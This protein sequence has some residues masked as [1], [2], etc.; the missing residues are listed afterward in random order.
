MCFRAIYLGI[1]VIL[2][3]I[4]IASYTDSGIG[5]FAD[6]NSPEKLSQ[7][8]VI[9]R[10]DFSPQAAGREPDVVLQTAAPSSML[11][12]NSDVRKKIAR[13]KQSTITSTLSKNRT[14]TQFWNGHR[15]DNLVCVSVLH[16]FAHDPSAFTQGVT[17]YKRIWF[18]STGLD[19]QS[20]L[21]KVNVLTGKP[22]R[23]IRLPKDV[24]AE[25]VE[26]MHNRVYQLTYRN[27]MVFLYDATTFQSIGTLPYPL[28]AFQE[29]WGITSDRDKRLFVSDGSSTIFV[30]NQKFELQRRLTVTDAQGEVSML[31]ELEY[32]DGEIW[33]NVFMTD[34]IIR[35]SPDDGHAI[36]WVIAGGL[37]PENDHPAV[38]VTNGI[39]FDQKTGGLFVSWFLSWIF[40]CSSYVRCH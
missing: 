5:V 13:A 1:F 31:N 3:H 32:I 40:F 6:R 25:G 30:L 38:K 33:A 15:N 20:S 7:V 12:Y 4:T 22:T 24:F 18:E 35:I 17:V 39:S 28:D 9:E 19:G 14:N 23:G 11:S 27:Q 10:R 16:E 21:R 36:G 29:G 2:C 8:S 34:C 26:V 37:W